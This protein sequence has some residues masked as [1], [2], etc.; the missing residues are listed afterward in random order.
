MQ[1]T[2]LRHALRSDLDT[3]VDVWVDAFDRD[4]FFRWIAP[5]DEAYASFATPWLSTIAQL[6]FE[7]GHTYL[8]TTANVATG[9][10]PPDLSLVS[11]A[12]VEALH[13]I[14]A[15]HAGEARAD[16][17]LEAIMT[18]RSHSI[19]APHWTL[20]YLGARASR[21]GT[22]LGVV[23]VAPLL[24][25]CDAD[26]LACGLVSTNTRNVSF[27]QRLGFLTAAEVPVADGPAVLRPMHRSPA[28]P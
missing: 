15:G 19:G 20:Q 24:A 6:L 17:A 13:G 3:I 1:A 28:T 21:H 4:P 16:Q 23:A 14:V 25:R 7:R 11:P 9:W 22:G 5:T 2:A 12:N 8:D 27:Y 18:A 26:G 10:V